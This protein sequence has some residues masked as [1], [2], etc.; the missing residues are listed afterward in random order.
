M[1]YAFSVS[2]LLG[3]AEKATGLADWG[4]DQFRKP[5]E[6]LISDLNNE[7]GL[8]PLGVVRAK[9]RLH[10]I[11]CSRLK[12]I[13]DRK[14]FPGIAQE[15]IKQP[16]F[17]LG[18]P[19]AGTTFF[20]NI[21]SADP[22]NRS[23]VTWEIMYPSPPPEAAIYDSDPRIA[24]ARAAMD[25][26]GFMAPELQVIHPFDAERPEECNFIWEMS[27][28]TVNFSAW[29]NLPNYGRLLGSSDF[30][31]VHAEHKQTLQHLQH[32]FRRKR[33]VL[34][35]PAHNLWID[36]LLDIYPDAR[37][38]QCHR[39]PAKIVPSLSKNLVVWRKTFSDEASISEFGSMDT[40]VSG[41]KNLDRV[42]DRPGFADRFFDAHYL[43]VQADP[44]AV[45]AKAYRHF[46]LPLPAS[47]EAAMR[48][49]LRADRD[50][51]AKGPRHVYALEHYDLDYT[52]VDRVF[53]DYIQRHGVALE[54]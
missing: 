33:W 10:D 1:S 25:A 7:A 27:F 12:L 23:P 42:R 43:D 52:K 3:E 50:G 26:E 6:V 38:I 13:E 4:A 39:D 20:H 21:L 11:L 54:R 40:L 29:W 31:W 47:N 17:V 48:S 53:G 2:T 37:F 19:R 28:M 22:D 30:H 34:K 16:I 15:E 14:R 51:H 8:N 49:W 45:A 44:M 5:F 24:K 35:T 9:R 18:L 36:A 32:R 41:L 46:G